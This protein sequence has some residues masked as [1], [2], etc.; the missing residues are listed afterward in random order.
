MLFQI[1]RKKLNNSSRIT[2]EEKLLK[3]K[4]E[5]EEMLRRYKDKIFAMSAIKNMGL[6]AH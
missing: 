2:S 1:F 5:T 6:K 4:R 3:G